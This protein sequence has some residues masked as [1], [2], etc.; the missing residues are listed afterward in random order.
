MVAIPLKTKER[1]LKHLLLTEGPLSQRNC[2]STLVSAKTKV[3]FGKEQ[4]GKLVALVFVQIQELAYGYHLTWHL[5][6]SCMSVQTINFQ[7][8]L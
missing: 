4:I 5:Q 2:Q 6:F 1:L 8:L 7:Y 3:S